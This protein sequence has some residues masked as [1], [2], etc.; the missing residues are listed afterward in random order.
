MLLRC[1]ITCVQT[2]SAESPLICQP[3]KRGILSKI[4]RCPSSPCTGTLKS[5]NDA[6]GVIS[7]VE[8]GELLREVRRRA[9]CRGRPWTSRYFRASSFCCSNKPNAVCKTLFMEEDTCP[10]DTTKWKRQLPRAFY[11]SLQKRWDQ[12]QASVPG[13]LLVKQAV[14]SGKMEMVV[15]SGKTLTMALLH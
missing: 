8:L 12:R 11:D 13:E 9:L 1:K 15:G 2:T 3:V 4:E 5:P 14:G 10:A 6:A 7:V